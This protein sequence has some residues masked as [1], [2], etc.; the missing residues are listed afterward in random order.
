[1]HVI[2][3]VLTFSSVGIYPNA[4]IICSREATVPLVYPGLA[5]I[6]EFDPEHGHMGTRALQSMGRSQL[7]GLAEL[8]LLSRVDKVFLPSTD[9]LTGWSMD[10]RGTKCS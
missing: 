1:M 4:C 10:N 5:S 7:L 3:V 2:G 6:R 8:D 9:R